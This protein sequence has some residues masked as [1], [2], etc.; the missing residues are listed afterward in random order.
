MTL[1]TE[2]THGAQRKK[3]RMTQYATDKEGD[4][5]YRPNINEQSLNL[6]RGMNDIMEDTNRKLAKK[7]FYEEN[8]KKKEVNEFKYQINSTSDKV[9]HDRFDN[10]FHNACEELS[11]L[12]DERELHETS[13]GCAQMS[14]VFLTLG[15]VSPIAKESEQF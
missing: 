10:D 9:M 14:Q 5:N 7:A 11:I 8:L 12:R 6:D 2:I 4:F 3:E 1:N 15:F 13:V